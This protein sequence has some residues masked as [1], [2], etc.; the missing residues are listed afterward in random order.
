MMNLCRHKTQKHTEL[1]RHDRGTDHDEG[2]IFVRGC[3]AWRGSCL[4]CI[5]SHHSCHWSEHRHH[6]NH[7]SVSRLVVASQPFHFL[8]LSL[9]SK[10]AL[11]LR[12]FG[13]GLITHLLS[14]PPPSVKARSFHRRCHVRLL[15]SVLICENRRGRGSRGGSCLAMLAA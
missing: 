13:R 8:L 1:K 10:P 7:L 12:S 6:L 14:P 9:L 4:G 11:P 3:C 15:P 5:T 2:S